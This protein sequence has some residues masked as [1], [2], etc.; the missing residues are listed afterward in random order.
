MFIVEGIITLVVGCL[1]IKSVI[2]NNKRS[3]EKKAE[4]RREWEENR[5]ALQTAYDTALTALKAETSKENKINALEAGR[6]YAAHCRK[7][8]KVSI[9]DEAALQND[10]RAYGGD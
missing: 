9:F 1:I 8:G 7:G 2:A 6:A 3:E 4:T 5:K 10:L